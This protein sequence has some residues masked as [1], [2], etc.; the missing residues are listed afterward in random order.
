M[1][2]VQVTAPMHG[3]VES[4]EAKEGQAVAAGGPLVVLEAMKMQH[5][6]EAPTAGIVR[7]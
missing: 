5:V 4:V 7:R 2:E 6:V 3:T 1:A